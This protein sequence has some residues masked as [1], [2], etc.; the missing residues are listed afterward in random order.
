MKKGKQNPFQLFLKIKILKV[1]SGY[2][3]FQVLIIFILGTIAD[4]INAKSNTYVMSPIWFERQN[5][6][7]EKRKS[8]RPQVLTWV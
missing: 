1:G 3:Y 2:L 6:T 4:K 8:R 7:E 5:R